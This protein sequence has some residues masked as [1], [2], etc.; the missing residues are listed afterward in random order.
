MAPIL[1]LAVRASKVPLGATIKNSEF[2]E[3]GPIGVLGSHPPLGVLVE[4][5]DIIWKMMVAFPVFDTE[6]L[7]ELV[8]RLAEVSWNLVMYQMAVETLFFQSFRSPT[9]G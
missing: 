4:V 6:T 5:R 8:V 1:V 9:C 3:T 2:F 7:R